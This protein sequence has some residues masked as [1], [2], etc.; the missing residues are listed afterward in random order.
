MRRNLRLQTELL[1]E[2]RKQLEI[3]IADNMINLADIKVLDEAY[4]PY[5]KSRP[6]RALMMIAFAILAGFIQLGVIVSILY[7]KKF[8]QELNGIT[9]AKT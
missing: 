5:R 8:K 3:F 2:F 7:Y 6:K 1:V 9:V 4:A